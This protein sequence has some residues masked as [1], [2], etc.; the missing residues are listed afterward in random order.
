MGAYSPA[1]VIDA[2]NE[3]KLDQIMAKT[4]G[5]RSEMHMQVFIF[6]DNAH[7]SLD[8]RMGDACQAILPRM[9]L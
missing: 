6:E 2:E 5:M 4:V 1:T 8:V 3:K 7:T 9:V